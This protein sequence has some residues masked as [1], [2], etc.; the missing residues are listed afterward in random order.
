MTTCN[1]RL[2]LFGGTG[3]WFF[4]EDDM[5]T[6]EDFDENF[7]FGIPITC[8]GG[9]CSLAPVQ[10]VADTDVEGVQNAGSY[11][12]Y[13]PLRN[14]IPTRLLLREK[15]ISDPKVVTNLNVV[16]FATSQPYYGCG[17]YPGETRYWAIDCAS[18][19]GISREQA[20]G[21]IVSQLSTS[22][23]VSL[24]IKGIFY[25]ETPSGETTVKKTTTFIAG[26]APTSPIQIVIPN[27]PK[28]GHLILWLQY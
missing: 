26:I 22:Q 19:G 28:K 13:T 14:A 2:Y 6:H 21:N 7:I 24:P 9:S 1:N 25:E 20:E 15:N 23:I 16:Y 5:E 11:G 18:G 10:E 27:P 12:W 4:K 3:R 17:L 8:S